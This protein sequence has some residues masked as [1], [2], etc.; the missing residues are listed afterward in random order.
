MD[1]YLYLEYGVAVPSVA[2]AI[3][4]ARKS[5]VYDMEDVTLDAVN[6]HAVGLQQK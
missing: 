5:A 3:Q 2:V 6:I 4:K 1:I